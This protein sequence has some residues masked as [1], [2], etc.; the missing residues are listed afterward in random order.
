M[1]IV[2]ALLLL[3]NCVV[4]A[5]PKVEAIGPLS[6]ASVS[7]AVRG[8]LE[9]A[10]YR[11]V[12]PDG[13]A[14]CEIWL[15]KGLSTQA[16]TDAQGAIYSFFPDS[17][18]IGVISFSKQTTDF[19]GQAIKPGFY[20]LRYA[21]HPADGNHLGI[22]PNRDFLLMSPVAA[23]RDPNSQLKFED[24]V[25]MSKQASGTNHP[26]GLSLVSTEGQGKG[27]SA[28]QDD[29]R[30]TILIAGLKPASGAEIP[31]AL[32]VKGVAEQ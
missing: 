14:A 4:S 18:L 12:L 1:P 6:E 26:S 24:L 19:R 28:M 23:D 9:S 30:H 3:L 16:K 31:I 8:A 10:G 27:P 29:S 15:R 21:L 32:I 17:A 5:G 13:S 11:V 22:S 2:L 25:K 7:D 20:T